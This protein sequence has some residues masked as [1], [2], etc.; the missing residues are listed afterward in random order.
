MLAIMWAGIVLMAAGYFYAQTQP[1]TQ[2][3]AATAMILLMAGLA[4]QIVA[5]VAEIISG[6]NR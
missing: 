5:T 2:E 3:A 4:T 6:F 1:P